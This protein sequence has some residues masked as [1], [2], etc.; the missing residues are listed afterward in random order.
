M[1]HTTT[2]DVILI[3]G[4]LV[5]SFAA[6]LTCWHVAEAA[7]LLLVYAGTLA[8]AARVA[9]RGR[10]L[11]GGFWLLMALPSFFVM[12]RLARP[13]PC[14]LPIRSRWYV[15]ILLLSV[16]LFATAIAGAIRALVIRLR[17]A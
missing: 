3:A 8:I 4:G 7:S 5:L 13:L 1:H 2:R 14:W 15:A 6:T 16:I 12:Y 11:L 10:M 17:P 9:G